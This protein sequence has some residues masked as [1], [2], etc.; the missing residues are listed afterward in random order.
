MTALMTNV[1]YCALMLLK[2]LH[3]KAQNVLKYPGVPGLERP[4]PCR[5]HSKP[6]H[7]PT[8]FLFLPQVRVPYS[9]DC[10]TSSISE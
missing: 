4:V 2:A 7:P 1:G 9:S 5:T 8:Y 3:D 10:K 6:H